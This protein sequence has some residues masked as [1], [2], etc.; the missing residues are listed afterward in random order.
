[1][2]ERFPLAERAVPGA[3]R[4]VENAAAITLSERRPGSVVEIAL[5]DENT[6]VSKAIGLTAQPRPGSVVASPGLLCLSTAP[7]RLTVIAQQPGLAERIATAT[8]LDRGT[9][10]DQTHG[11]AGLRISGAPAAT[12]VQKGVSFDVSAFAPMSATNA[13]LHHMS[14]T[15]VRLDAVTFDLFVATS[16]AGSLWDRVA[17]AAIEYGWRTGTPVF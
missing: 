17:D 4:P 2:S 9:V 3:G 15:V 16:L 12:L 10:V 8:D 14:A 7:G 13:G 5:W 1:M 6:N 11:R